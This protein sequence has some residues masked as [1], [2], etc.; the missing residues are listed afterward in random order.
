MIARLAMAFAVLGFQEWLFWVFR[1]AAGLGTA[2]IAWLC[3]GPVIQ[4]LVRAAFHKKLPNWAVAW[5]RLVGAILLGVLVYYYLPL[6]GGP[7]W[8]PGS[9][10]PGAG[11]GSGTADENKG[12]K[13]IPPGKQPE[14]KSATKDSAEAGTE[15]LH[16]ELL[17]GARYKNDERYYLLDR[18][19]PAKTLADVDE[20]LQQNPGRYKI[21]HLVLT[22]D[23]VFEEHPAVTRLQR[24]AQQ[25]YKLAAPIVQP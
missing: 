23:S 3:L 13:Q 5:L 20:F 15:I 10:G 18:K 17:G 22:R 6:G 4:L 21:V 9:G 12:G 14:S 11:P 16:I 24:L 7:G 19:E 25:K 8:G 1:V 2:F